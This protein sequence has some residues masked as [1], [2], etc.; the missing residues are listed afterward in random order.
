MNENSMMPDGGNPLSVTIAEKSPNKAVN[1][2]AFF[3]RVAHYKCAGYGRRYG[4]S[5]SCAQTSGF[6]LP[7]ERTPNNE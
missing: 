7:P 2:D 5:E 4:A 6:L 3:V 1:A